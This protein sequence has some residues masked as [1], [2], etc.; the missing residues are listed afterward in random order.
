MPEDEG[1]EDARTLFNAMIDK[2]PAVIAQCASIDDVV[3]AV[4]FGRETGLPTAVR[5][6]GHPSPGCRASRAGSSI[7][8]RPMKEIEVDPAGRTVRCGSGV[9]WG[10]LDPA[11]QE[12]GLATTGGRVSTTGV[13]G[14]T[15][16]GGSGWLERSTG[17]PATTSSRSSS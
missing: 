3:A 1:Y 2:R 5:S 9:T 10:E 6:G 15:L 12:H 7:D 13:A 14:F 8:V 4:R 16:G 11:T 17:S